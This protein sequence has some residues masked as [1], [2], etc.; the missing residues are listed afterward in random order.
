MVLM[1]L[2][3]Q[4]VHMGN[5]MLIFKDESLTKKIGMSRVVYGPDSFDEEVLEI[6]HAVP[7]TRMQGLKNDPMPYELGS[8]THAGW[9]TKV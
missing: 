7:G 6:R 8:F 2:T 5:P 4:S 9:G 3:E 1:Y